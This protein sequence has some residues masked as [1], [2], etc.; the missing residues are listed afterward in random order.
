MLRAASPSPG[1]ARR[2]RQ[3][4]ARPATIY[5]EKTEYDD[6]PA[7][8]VAVSADG[9]QRR[10]LLKDPQYACCDVPSPDGKRITFL[11]RAADG[12]QLTTGLVNADGSGYQVMPLPDA[13]VNIGPNIWLSD[14]DI[15]FAAWDDDDPSQNGA[16]VGDPTDPASIHRLTTN[17]GGGTDDALALSSDGS[18]VAFARTSKG[19]SDAT[20]W[21][22]ELASGD[23][24]QVSPPGSI[25]KDEAYWGSPFSWSPDGQ[26][27]AYTSGDVVMWPL[28]HRH[29][30]CAR[31][32]GA[33]HRRL[34][35][36]WGQPRRTLVARWAVGLLRR[37]GP[38]L[39]ARP[40]V[41]GPP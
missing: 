38:G 24:W 15:V 13:S 9:S 10:E 19:S 27:L 20:L 18:L 34:T 23:T 12:T 7:S 21:V 28:L 8:L 31:R 33:A 26:R 1:H 4:V 36:G 30:G 32:T 39:R 25:I 35:G 11:V 5:F 29:R 41:A 22:V 17:P 3:S 6:G 2:H 16:Y 40:G 37:A 14:S